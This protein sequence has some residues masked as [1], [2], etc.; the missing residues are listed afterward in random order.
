M[1]IIHTLKKFIDYY[2]VLVGIFGLIYTWN[3]PKS[4]WK[5]FPVFLIVLGVLDESGSIVSKHFGQVYVTYYYTLFIIPF[6]IIYFLWILNKNM[7]TDRR[8]HYLGLVLY[9]SSVIAEILIYRNNKS[10][11]FMSLSYTV[12]NLVLLANILR[13]FYQ[14]SISEKILTFFQE[15]MFWISLGLLIFWLGALPYY[16]I[17]N[18]LYDSYPGIFTFY[19]PFMM[20]F[21]YTMYTCFL[22]SFIWG[23]KS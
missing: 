9:F 1:D 20:L 15:R 8:L 18:F 22:V 10:P 5:S 7:K 17:F 6:Q 11:Y 14:L 21:N 23:R 3:Q 2:I 13:Y 16:G 12:G 4:Y 19:Y